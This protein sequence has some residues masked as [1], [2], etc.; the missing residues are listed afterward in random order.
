MAVKKKK[1]QNNI[2]EREETSP[3]GVD[4]TSKTEMETKA[5]GG[6]DGSVDL[7]SRCHPFEITECVYV[8][9]R[10]K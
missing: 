1:E 8:Y 3:S 4:V 2:P 6:G 9:T 10:F 7:V 5:G